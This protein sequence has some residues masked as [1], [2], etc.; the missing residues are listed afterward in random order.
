MFGKVGGESCGA[1][2]IDGGVLRISGFAAA[3]EDI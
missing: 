3:I 1:Y 2:G